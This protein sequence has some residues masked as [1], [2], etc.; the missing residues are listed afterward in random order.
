MLCKKKLYFCFIN[1]ES[2]KLIV[3]FEL[4]I[5]YYYLNFILLEEVESG[6]KFF[7]G[8]IYKI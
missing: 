7:N 2:E 1:R 3:R 8:G 4:F 6:M 5:D